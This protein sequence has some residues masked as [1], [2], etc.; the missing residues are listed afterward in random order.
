MS[1]Y[2]SLKVNRLEE[3]QWNYSLHRKDPNLYVEVKFGNTTRKTQVAK[4]SQSPVW[5]EELVLIKSD[6]LLTGSANGEVHLEVL[7]P[8]RAEAMITGRL[9]LQLV[10]KS[11]MEATDMGLRGVTQSVQRLGTIQAA[12]FSIVAQPIDGRSTQAGSQNELYKAVDGLLRR[13]EGLENV[14]DAVSE[15]H[16]FSKIAWSL[17]S[18]LFKAVQN[19][20]EADKKVVELVQVMNEAFEFTRDVQTLRDKATTLQRPIE[21]L[22]K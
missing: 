2:Y 12:D 20:F 15:A 13:L 5:D 9:M 18:A 21:G 11:A 3:L 10:V 4:R 6:E 19:G 16:P 8:K 7:S 14:I 1:S 22:L 17:V